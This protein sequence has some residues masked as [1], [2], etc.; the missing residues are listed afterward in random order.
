MT[1]YA[2][3]IDETSIEYPPMNYRGI[4]NYDH[5]TEALLEDGYKPLVEAEKP[6]DEYTIFYKELKNSIKE[7]IHIVTEEEKQARERARLD[8]L[9][10]T[11]RVF[12]LI[13]EQMGVTYA[14]VKQLIAS[15]EQAQ[16][17]WDLCVELLR[18]NPFLDTMAA[19]MGFTSAD[20]DYIFKVANGEIIP[21]QEIDLGDS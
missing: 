6:E 16:M 10:C 4:S 20:L 13:L 2:K 19:Q 9:T 17:E 15:S 7:V 8:S 18:G 11:K 21:E 5:C 14:Q 1:K 3:F 12:M